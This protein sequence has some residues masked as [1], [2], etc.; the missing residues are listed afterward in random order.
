MKFTKIFDTESAMEAYLSSADLDTYVFY[1]IETDRIV[2][3]GNEPHTPYDEQY[4]T[5]VA[6]EDNMSV[7]LSDANDNVYQYSIDNGA[8]WSNLANNQSTSAVNTGEKILFKA[9]GLT[10]DYL[11]GIGK[12][13]PSAASSVEG[14]IM[15]LLY[16]DNF[17]GQTVI[18]NARQFHKLFE[19]VTSL[20]SAENLVLPATTLTDYCYFAMFYGCSGLT[21]APSILPATTL[22]SYCYFYMFNRCNLTAAPELPAT[23]LVDSCYTYMFEM[24]AN[25]N[26]IKCLATDISASHCTFRWVNGVSATGTFVM[27]ASMD[28]GNWVCGNSGVPFGWDGYDENGNRLEL[29]CAM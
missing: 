29:P 18:S 19:N 5:F 28:G 13:I 3:S 11:K 26:Y 23:T 12:L 24:N 25:L 20:V 2:Y 16:G 6:M 14:N 27:P 21:S 22:A 8:T 4:L 7:G 17:V 9:S 15:S 10:A 1:V